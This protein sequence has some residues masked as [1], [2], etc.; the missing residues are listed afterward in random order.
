[1]AVHGCG[2]AAHTGSGLQ[3]GGVRRL[4][5]ASE[6]IAKERTVVRYICILIGWFCQGGGLWAVVRKRCEPS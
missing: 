1:M 2:N 6:R 4:Q 3:V 5:V